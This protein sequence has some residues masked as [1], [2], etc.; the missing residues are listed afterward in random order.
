MKERKKIEDIKKKERRRK[1]ERK[2]E[3]RKKE[4]EKKDLRPLPGVWHG[5]MQSRGCNATR[6]SQARVPK[7]SS[8]E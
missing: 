4:E 2:K 3:E 5:A 8:A 1:E 6:A 7:A